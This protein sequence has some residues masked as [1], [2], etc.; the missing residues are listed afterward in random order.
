MTEGL[1][2]RRAA[3]QIL[4][5]VL[6]R[7]Q[8][9]DAAS[10]AIRNLFAPDRA[11]AVAIAGETLRR[12]PDLDALIDSATRNRLPDDSKARNVLRL[13]LAQK[14]GL[15]T[16]EHAL[17]A[18]ALPLVD[19]GPRR[20]VHGV[21][22]TLLRRGV[23]LMEAPLLPPEVERRWGETWGDDVVAA[24]RRQ[25]ARRPALDLTFIDDGEAQAFAAQQSGVSLAPRHVR[26][27]S[28]SVTELPGFGEGRWWVQDLAAS[29]P[30]RVVPSEARE[31]LDLC[32]AP[33][34]KTMQLAAAGHAVTS[35][36]ASGSR[37][38]RLRENL[39]RTHLNADLVE[40][41][42]LKW[43]PKQQYDA[44]LL[45][46]PCSATGTFRR[47]PEVLYRARPRVIAEGAE[48]QGQLLDRA[49]QW[50]T[51]NGTL[52]YAVCSLEKPEGEDVVTAF[53][54]RQRGFR[55]LKP[56]GLP[57][58]ASMGGD[59]SGRIL[60]GLLESD[61]GLDGFF[62]ARLVRAD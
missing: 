11:L 50:L 21:L 12:L 26:I 30:A 19:G 41:D 52:I 20:L 62:I 60:P 8:T 27:E 46:A 25:I 16:P 54:D 17:V 2:A 33:G 9:I 32:A 58:F 28:S 35:V 56:V 13:A 29:L 47:H 51:P 5:A 3:L 53:L 57:D 39:E 40:A 37:L 61:G 1:G 18:T 44:I 36:D 49:A 38:G 59:N 48:L 22:G 34:G 31:V 14:I 10:S 6:R 4:D 43:R 7:G 24:A 42:A 15:Q 45:D 55:L 23:P